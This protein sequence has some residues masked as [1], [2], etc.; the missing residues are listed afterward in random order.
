MR[1]LP[2]RECL[3]KKNSQIVKQPRIRNSPTGK[4][5]REGK[6]SSVETIRT[7]NTS[8]GEKIVERENRTDWV[9]AQKVRSCVWSSPERFNNSYRTA[10]SR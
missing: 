5:S 10:P 9:T 7:G 1:K 6:I 8:D 2:G 3:G 4:R